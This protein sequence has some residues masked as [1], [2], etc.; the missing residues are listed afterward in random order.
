METDPLI[1]PGTLIFRGWAPQGVLMYHEEL[2]SLCQSIKG[3]ERIRFWMTFGEEYLTHLRVLQTGHGVI[4]P[5]MHDGKEIVPLK[6]LKS[7]LPDP[8][9]LGEQYEGKTCIRSGRR[10]K[11]QQTGFCL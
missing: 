11:R 6:F 1:S 9:S 2:E 7:V 10:R 8:G 5:V 3:L 4:E